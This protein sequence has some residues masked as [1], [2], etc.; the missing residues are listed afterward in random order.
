MSED[1][2]P[3]RPGSYKTIGVRL[4]TPIHAQLSTIAGID[5]L[6][7]QVLLVRGAKLLI[8]AKQAAPDFK[9]RVTAELKKIELEAA[10]RRGAIESLFGSNSQ[11]DDVASTEAADA[12]AITEE[13]D[14]KP[15]AATAAKKTTARS[16]AP[17]S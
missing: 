1:E 17:K 8:E 10:E 14:D 16:S 9:D 13:A 11:T 5:D 7:L 6:S 12:S 4:Q 2:N 15:V 3:T